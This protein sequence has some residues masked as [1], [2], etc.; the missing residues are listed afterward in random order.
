MKQEVIL[1]T[2]CMTKEFLQVMTAKLKVPKVNA[3]QD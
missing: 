3:K 2:E 1:S